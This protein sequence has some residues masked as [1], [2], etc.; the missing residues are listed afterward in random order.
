[1]PTNLDL[2][3]FSLCARSSAQNNKHRKTGSV[4]WMLVTQ[5]CRI[6]TRRFAIFLVSHWIKKEVL[7]QQFPLHS[8]PCFSNNKKKVTKTTKMLL[9]HDLMSSIKYKQERIYT[10]SISKIRVLF[11]N[12]LYKSQ[13]K[14]SIYLV[15]HLLYAISL[16][17]K[18]ILLNTEHFAD[19]YRLPSYLQREGLNCCIIL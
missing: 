2:H 16:R 11:H 18:R 4:S 1:M 17:A 13:R 10:S 19:I 8:V 6:I 14:K 12:F 9:N 7:T 5:S 15:F 3:S